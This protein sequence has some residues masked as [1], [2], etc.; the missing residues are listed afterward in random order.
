MDKFTPGPWH[1]GFAN[2]KENEISHIGVRSKEWVVCEVQTDVDDLPGEANAQLIAAAPDL[3]AALVALSNLAQECIENI[4]DDEQ[5]VI[6]VAR[7][8]IEKATKDAK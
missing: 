6:E 1:V 3:L 5:A 8:A 2:V 4:S 7:A